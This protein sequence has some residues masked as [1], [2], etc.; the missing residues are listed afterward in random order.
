VCG[1]ASA[2]ACVA[3]IAFTVLRATPIARAIARTAMP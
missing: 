1:F 3:R 2:A